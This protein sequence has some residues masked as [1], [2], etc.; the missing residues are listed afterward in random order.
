MPVIK[1]YGAPG[2]I[3]E[4]DLRKLR[5]ALKE[6]V[7]SMP[8]LGIKPR[9]V[10]PYFLSDRLETTLFSTRDVVV[11]IFITKKPGRTKAVQDR[12]AGLVLDLV[13]A[14][15]GRHKPTNV[16]VFVW[17]HD[18]KK[19]GFASWNPDDDDLTSSAKEKPNPS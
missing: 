6:A 5:E 19:K 8:E 3:Y 15:F 9:Q 18:V 17:D 16:E 1:V 11:E 7:G 12:L 2:E 13:K 14:A 4:D 10:S